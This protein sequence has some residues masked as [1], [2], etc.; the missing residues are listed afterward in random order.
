MSIFIWPTRLGTRIT[1]FK[2]NS[3]LGRLEPPIDDLLG[4]LD[5]RLEG[6][7]PTLL[8]VAWD[9]P[10]GRNDVIRQT[11]SEETQQPA[12]RVHV[13]G[14]LADVM[15]ETTR[16]PGQGEQKSNHKS[17]EGTQVEPVKKVI[18]AVWGECEQV[19]EDEVAFAYEKVVDKHYTNNR[20]LEDGVAAEEVEETVCRRDDAPACRE[21]IS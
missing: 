19:G 8:V 18:P 2:P 21:T 7:I 11:A 5:P 17:G 16:E 14:G 20:T 6:Q 12:Q 10:D 15:P 9:L 1:T 4:S 3:Q 13:G